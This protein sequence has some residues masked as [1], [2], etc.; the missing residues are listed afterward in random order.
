MWSFGEQLALPFDRSADTPSNPYSEFE[1]AVVYGSRVLESV[2]AASQ[3]V[4]PFQRMAEVI[5]RNQIDGAMCSNRKTLEAH[6]RAS[7]VASAHTSPVGTSESELRSAVCEV[8][9]EGALNG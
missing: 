1:P 8:S 4:L 6:A 7:Q 5:Q 9:Q 2:S 3:A